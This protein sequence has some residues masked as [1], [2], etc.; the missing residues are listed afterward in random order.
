MERNH[1]GPV[2]L[3]RMNATACSI[4]V[5]EVIETMRPLPVAPLSDAPPFVCGMAIIRGIPTPVIELGALFQADQHSPA[6]RFVTVRSG[7]RVVALSVQSV[8]GVVELDHAN[9]ADLPPLLQNARTEVIEAIGRLDAE[10]LV[11]LKTSRLVP[12][13]LWESLGNCEGA[14]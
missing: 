1:P 9:I 4:P 3:V 5:S 13:S 7:G 8:M 11:M 10:F 12:E 6:G 2:L 14:R